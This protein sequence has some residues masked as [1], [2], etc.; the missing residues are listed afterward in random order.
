MTYQAEALLH[1]KSES[2]IESE[3]LAYP[4]DQELL[5]KS[6]CSFISHGTERLVTT[7]ELSREIAERMSVPYMKGSLED[8]FKYGYSLVGKVVDGDANFI[9][10]HV[11]LMHPHQDMCVVNTVDVTVLP[12]EMDPAVAS[13]ASNLETAVNAIW[14]SGIEIGDRVQV[15]GYGII[16]AL[17]SKL[18]KSYPG[19]HIDILET[20]PG[21]RV[22][23]MEH[24]YNV[25]AEKSE[26]KYDIV[27]NTS[28]GEG[29]LQSA[30]ESTV[31]EGKII[32]LSWYGLR[33]TT[34]QLGSDF[35]YGRKQI[36]SS[37]V[38]QIPYRKQARWNYVTRKELVL[39]LLT[40][41][42]FSNFIFGRISFSE[43]PSF[44]HQLRN[45]KIAD[46]STIITY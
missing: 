6:I 4:G 30:I 5:I 35:H 1:N 38:S 22:V 46:L 26:M 13:L 33:S 16:G 25:C 31:A 34:L 37:Q 42:D 44:Y 11:H 39:A 12:D 15:I 41:L 32:E 17:I 29:A 9:G 24:G 40:Q 8:T 28:A 23:A 36:I 7:D 45:N 2:W 10:Q 18:V 19:I 27:F 21:R 20:N 14:D 3:D 43:A